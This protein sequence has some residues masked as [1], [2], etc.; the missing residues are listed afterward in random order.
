VEVPESASHEAY[1]FLSIDKVCHEFLG[2]YTTIDDD[3]IEGCLSFPDVVYWR[4]LINRKRLNGK[5]T[6]L[7]SLVHHVH[8]C[9]EP[10]LHVVAKVACSDLDF[11]HE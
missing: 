11:V 5:E 9:I 8:S 10:L 3:F 7:D 6:E 2:L 1:N 4:L